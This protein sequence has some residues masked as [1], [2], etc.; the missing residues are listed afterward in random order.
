MSVAQWS[1]QGAA[2]DLEVSDWSFDDKVWFQLH[3]APVTL[4]SEQPAASAGSFAIEV[5]VRGAVAFEPLTLDGVPLVTS[6]AEA[7]TVGPFQA[8]LVGVRAVASGV[9]GAAALT[10]CAW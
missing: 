1:D 7:L 4:G 8:A 6:A 9:D 2:R 3:L 5:K 10:V